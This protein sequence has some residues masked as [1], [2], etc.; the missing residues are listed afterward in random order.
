MHQVLENRERDTL[1]RVVEMATSSVR[2]G[3]A[4]LTERYG[5]SEQADINAIPI[6]EIERI[7]AHAS[8]S[9]AMGGL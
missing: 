5:D 1:S 6:E 7:V 3:S 9:L 4:C 2:A 8:F